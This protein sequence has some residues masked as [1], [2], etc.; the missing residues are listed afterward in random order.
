MTPIRALDIA[1]YERWTPGRV[2]LHM[3]LATAIGQRR[4][5]AK[6][7]RR[8]WPWLPVLLAMYATPIVLAA[9]VAVALWVLRRGV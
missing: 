7:K 8:W 6:R 1:R 4:T 3:A 2:A 5:P 9:S